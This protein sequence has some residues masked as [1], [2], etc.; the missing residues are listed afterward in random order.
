MT[1]SPTPSAALDNLRGARALIT[2]GAGFLGS[3]LALA[4]VERGAAVTIVDAM[5]PHYGGNLFNLAP[6]QDRCDIHFTDIRDVH[7]MGYLVRNQD[8][9]FHLAG[10]VDHILSLTDPFPDIDINVKG[11]A[12]LMEALRHHNPQ[13]RVIY[14]GTRGQYGRPK[15][16]PVN[17][18]AAT[19]PLGIYEIT[20]LAAEK[21]IEVYRKVFGIP[22][23]LLRITNTYGPRAQMRHSRYGVV[24]WFV[25]LAL[26]DQTIPVFG[27]GTIVRDFLYVDDCIAA[28]LLCAVHPA[29]V[30]QVFNVGVDRPIDFRTLAE[31]VVRVAGQGRWEL[32]DF[33]PERK[34]QEPGG[35]YSDIGK[36]RRLLGWSPQ[37]ELEPGLTRT[38]EY[39]RA[40]RE[41]YW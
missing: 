35:F 22:S 39:Y 16:L 18:E 7:A 9:V 37:V 32:A 25:R 11:T 17:E 30:G 13:A 14:S 36:I 15:Q 5:L 33:S 38:V 12:V 3:S 1:V 31:T 34:A 21:I 28:M 26:D 20:N 19:E 6:V 23:T 4:L 29:A 41:H 10:Q 24:N 40:H 8:L 2:G 27:D